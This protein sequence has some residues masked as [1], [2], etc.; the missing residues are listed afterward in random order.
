MHGTFCQTDSSLAALENIPS[1]YFSQI[2]RKVNLYK[3]RTT[4]KTIRTLEKLSRWERRIQ[5]TLEKAD[6]VTAKR[7]FGEGKM[8]FNRLLQQIR[9]GEA[10][11]LRYKRNYE[12]YRDQLTTN[13][14]YLDKHK[15]YL[16]DQ[17]SR[18]LGKAREAVQ[19]L[20]HYEDSTE[21]IRQF[22]QERKKE[23]IAAAVKSMGQSRYLTKMNKE[24][25]YYAETI[26]NYKSILSDE[27]QLEQ[28]IKGILNTIPAFS[29]FLS[30]NS[31]LASLFGS[32][33]AGVPGEPILGLQTRASVQNLLQER[34]RGGGP[35]AQQL[36]S[37]RLQD[38]QSQLNAYKDKLLKPGAGNGGG[39]L[40]DFKPNMQKTK[41]FWQRMEWGTNL[42]FARN[43]TLLPTTMDLAL[44][45]GYKLNDKST[46]GLG[47]GYKMGLGTIN[48]IQFTTEGI[49]LRSFIDW[50][51]K[52]QF[53][54]TGGWE[55]NYLSGLPS[56][57]TTL[58]PGG[59]DQWQE[60][61]LIGIT[62][63]FKVKSKWFKQTN[64]QLL[65][66]FLARK[67]LPARQNIVFR[68]GYSF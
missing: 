15:D 11:A 42:Q 14:Q 52:K 67:S 19:L 26:K 51:I 54:V 36:V 48:K 34:I 32:P 8:S 30:K 12:Q 68:V 16:A 43:N 65:Y 49:N 22:I 1:K 53:Y 33:A 18:N 58:V 41:T 60:S 66:D 37:Q 63:K 61:A 13:L 38:A 17:T 62:K 23:L 21:A 59:Y 40:P 7:L 44:T 24:A 29:A 2:D 5:S 4:R 50:K 9:Q 20:N 56:V 31:M 39:E 64:V 6:P 27:A 55:M 3:D 10:S 35:N 46:I 57:T 25:W 45:A 47:A 28:T